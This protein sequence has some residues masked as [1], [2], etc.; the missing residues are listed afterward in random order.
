M[1]V[2]VDTNIFIAALIKEEGLI[3]D[4]IINSDFIF[5]FPEYEFQEIYKYKED[6]IKKAGYS[7][8]EFIQATPLLLN[9][10]RIVSNEE[11]CNYYNDANEIMNKIDPDDVIFIATALAFE[12]KIWSD[13]I[14]FKKQNKIK[15]FATEEMKSFQ[16]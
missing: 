15:V 6:I 8:V 14:H 11:I 2:V 7:E 10:M 16:D 1:K 5:L 3:R 4:I 9:H 12:A 13:D